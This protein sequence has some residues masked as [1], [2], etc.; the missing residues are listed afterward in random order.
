[1]IRPAKHV[2]ILRLTELMHE[3]HARS[4]YAT[5]DEP[6]EQLFKTICMQAIRGHGL[7]NACFM[8][9][10]TGDR[11]EGLIL[12]AV[13]RIYGIG[14]KLWAFDQFF[15]AT[16]AVEPMDPLRLAAAFDSWWQAVPNC[17]EAR[18][19]TNNVIG[20]FT[21]TDKI[22]ER[23]GYTRDGTLFSKELTA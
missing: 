11:V 3:M 18:P 22:W 1:M 20:D 17:I 23:L 7:G 2:D 10:V 4:R 21:R 9:A 8:V 14:R 5:R 16:D 15:Y 12:G 6:V 13:D 19:S